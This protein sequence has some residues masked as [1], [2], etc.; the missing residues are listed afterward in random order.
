MPCLFSPVG[1]PSC[2]QHSFI[3]P[4]WLPTWQKHHYTPLDCYSQVGLCTQQPPTSGLCLFDLKK[5]FDSVPH[6]ALL[7]K[8]YYLH[9]PMHLFSWLSN[10]LKQRLQ[11][12]V[13]HGCT[14]TWLPVVSGVPQ[15]SI[16][17]P[18]LFL[19]YINGIF[20]VQLSKGSTLLVY[21][22]D[23]LLFKALS[24]PSD[25]QELQ[26]DVDRICE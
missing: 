26:D 12:V 10:Y 23:I 7:N 19:L 8:L 5:A 22:D 24:S 13:L 9:L 3:Q 16:L 1:T 21:A 20:N 2:P 17:G 4:V 6:Q 14:S 18:I 11:R 15:D 25:M